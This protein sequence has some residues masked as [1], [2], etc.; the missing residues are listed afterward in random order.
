MKILTLAL[1]LIALPVAARADDQC[2]VG[3]QA[4]FAPV[5]SPAWTAWMCANFLDQVACTEG[6]NLCAWSV[7]DNSCK[8]K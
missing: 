8:V 3:A 4:C 7:P 5:D 1:L 6:S 2:T